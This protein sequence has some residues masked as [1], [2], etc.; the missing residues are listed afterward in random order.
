VTGGEQI[1]DEDVGYGPAR[2]LRP[3]EVATFAAALTEISPEE[4]RRRYNPE[5]MQTAEIYP[6]IWARTDEREENFQYLLEYFEQLKEFA[7]S[8]H[9]RGNGVIIYLS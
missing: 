6:D 4:F 9:E 2:L 3:L 8:A 7:V 1:G 5:A